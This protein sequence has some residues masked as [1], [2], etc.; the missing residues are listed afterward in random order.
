LLPLRIQPVL[1]SQQN[2]VLTFVLS[3][4]K[5]SGERF[6]GEHWQGNAC[7]GGAVPILFEGV[8]G[9]RLPVPAPD[10]RDAERCI[11]REFGKRVVTDVNFNGDVRR[12]VSAEVNLNLIRQR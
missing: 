3:A 4:G 12:G 8:N 5:K 1:K 7:R 11:D 9:Q 10:F 6:A 2:F